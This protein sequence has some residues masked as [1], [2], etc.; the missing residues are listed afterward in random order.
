MK[1]DGWTEHMAY[2]H[3][4]LQK[5]AVTQELLCHGQVA[6]RNL[7]AKTLRMLLGCRAKNAPLRTPA[8]LLP[9]RTNMNELTAKAS[10][11]LLAFNRQPGP[12]PLLIY[13]SQ[14][15]AVFPVVLLLQRVVPILCLYQ[16]GEERNQRSDRKPRAAH[17]GPAAVVA[18]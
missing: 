5:T 8:K 11:L 15:D 2:L 13:V 10:A 12:H 16:A 9:G 18:A 4:P 3:Q 6:F 7:P 1:G 14:K 17:V